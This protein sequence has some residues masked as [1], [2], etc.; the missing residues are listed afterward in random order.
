MASLAQ[1]EGVI[2]V[3]WSEIES[4]ADTAASVLVAADP[5]WL[6][7]A[8]M[9]AAAVEGVTSLFLRVILCFVE[10]GFLSGH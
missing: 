4:T 5:E 6:Q 8:K 1:S 7:G 10:L 9:Y 2:S 3:Q